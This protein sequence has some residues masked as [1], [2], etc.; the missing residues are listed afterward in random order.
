LAEPALSADGREVRADLRSI[1]RLDGYTPTSGMRARSSEM[2][3]RVPERDLARPAASRPIRVANILSSACRDQLAKSLHDGFLRMWPH[4]SPGYEDRNRD[5]RL[6]YG[7]GVIKVSAELA[8]LDGVLIRLDPLVEA[9]DVSDETRGGE[10]CGSGRGGTSV[11][12]G[13]FEFSLAQVGLGDVHA[14]EVRGARAVRG[15]RPDA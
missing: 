12:E 2:N 6:S 4:A 5:A 3:R 1:T 7:S 8:D 13:L 15:E 9:F 10:G 11:V 14:I